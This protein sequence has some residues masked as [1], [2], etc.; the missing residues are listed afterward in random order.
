MEQVH[1]DKEL[2]LEEVWAHAKAL[3]KESFQQEEWVVVEDAEE[4]MESAAAE[5]L[6]EVLAEVRIVN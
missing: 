2:A 4:R 1:K 5:V 3:Q 6:V